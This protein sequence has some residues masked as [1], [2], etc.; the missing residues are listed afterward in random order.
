MPEIVIKER[1]DRSGPVRIFLGKYSKTIL[2]EKKTHVSDSELEV[3]RHSHE[4]NHVFV[5]SEQL[6]K[7]KYDPVDCAKRPKSDSGGDEKGS[8][9]SSFFGRAGK[10][11]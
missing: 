8:G 7:V 3:L 6:G 10:G 2:R 9:K 11:T 4:S 1:V 5:C